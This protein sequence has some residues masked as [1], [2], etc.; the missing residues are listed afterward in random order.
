MRKKGQKNI[1]MRKWSLI[2]SSYSSIK[3][4]IV[5]KSNLEIGYYAFR[6]EPWVN[7]QT[8]VRPL[9]Q[10]RTSLTFQPTPIQFLRALG[11]LGLG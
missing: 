8:Y 7:G 10:N 9:P 4:K 1:T 6:I 11:F 3:K 2:T 5:E